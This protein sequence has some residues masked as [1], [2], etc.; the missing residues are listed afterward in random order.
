MPKDSRNNFPR[1]DHF[2]TEGGDAIGV[3][4]NEIVNIGL[5]E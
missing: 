2:V 3:A 5:S 1:L 4:N